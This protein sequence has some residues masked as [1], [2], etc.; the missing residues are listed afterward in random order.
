M[1]ILKV[2]HGYPLRYNAGSEVYSQTLCNA[3]AN[4]HEI[5]VFTR[6]ENAFAPD[7]TMHQE[8]DSINQQIRLNVVNIPLEKH[9]YQYRI[10]EVDEQFAMVLIDFKPDIVHI[11]HLNHLSTSLVDSILPKIPVV[12]TLHD[13]WLMCPRG[14]FIQRTPKNPND[15]WKLCTG[16]ND[17]KCATCCYGGYFSGAVEDFSF[18]SNYWVNWIHKRMNYMK[19][20]ISK[21][22]YFIAPAQYLL[23]KFKDDFAI[24]DKKLIYLDY[25]FDLERLRNRT[26]VPNEPFTFGYI[27][28]HTPAKG[29]QLLIEAF[30]KLKGNSRLRIWGRSRGENTN[31]LKT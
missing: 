30:G 14:Q 9:R 28:T 2:I 22:D 23:T 11:G 16:Q 31:A 6:E 18:D 15:V 21:V 3:L 24:P 27:G 26:R 10:A 5:Q 17:L 7:Y 1:K 13:Y 12:Y 19:S 29:I 20:L 25:G 4:K 8:T